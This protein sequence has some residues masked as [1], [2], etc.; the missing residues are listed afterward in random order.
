MNVERMT[1][2]VQEALNAA[3]SRALSERN[4]QTAPEHLLAAVLE[5]PDGIAAPI[6]TKAGLD[7]A[8]LGAKV[9]QA[10]QK[11]PRFSG[12]NADS[13]QVPVAPA[14][15]RLLS[16]A[17]DEAKKLNDDFVSVEHLLLAMSADPAGTGRLFK[18]SGVVARYVVDRAARRAWQPTR[19]DA[20]PGRHLSNARAVRPGSHQGSR[21]RENSI[22]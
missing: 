11:L 21:T 14:L 6:L 18:D 1:Q 9:E 4:T 10:I 3:Y 5:Q 8:A 20:K 13:N 16:A 17:D 12:S 2:R 22:R 15:T 19:N 7:A